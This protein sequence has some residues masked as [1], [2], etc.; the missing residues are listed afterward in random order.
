MSLDALKKQYAGAYAEDF[1]WPQPSPQSDED[2]GEETEGALYFKSLK[3][4][5]VS[6]CLCS[7]HQVATL[8]T[9]FSHYLTDMDCVPSS[10]P[11]AVVLDSVFSM[12]HQRSADKSSSNSNGKAGRDIAE[13]AAATELLLPKGS[14]RITSSVRNRNDFT[15]LKRVLIILN[16]ITVPFLQ[17]R[18][19]A[20]I[21]LRGLLRE[22]QQIG[23]DWLLNLYKKRL[24]AI[25]ADETGLG[26]T[27]QTV[28][29]LAHLAGQEGISQ[30]KIHCCF[31][32]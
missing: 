8:L 11:E 23:V 9:I 7:Q 1:E 26:K 3:A 17:T 12:D 18:S 13:V 2:D 4:N 5:S 29:Y 24:N 30:I 27:V 16:D 10:P 28:A 31:F 32:I 6:F 21:L 25:L 14:L 22:Y 20:P 15:Q 19:P